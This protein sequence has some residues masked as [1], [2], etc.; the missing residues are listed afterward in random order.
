[1]EWKEALT[2]G[3]SFN[4]LKRGLLNLNYGFLCL[5]TQSVL[6]VVFY[7]IKSSNGAEN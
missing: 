1:M 4:E 5:M 3:S 7:F 6:I 2:V